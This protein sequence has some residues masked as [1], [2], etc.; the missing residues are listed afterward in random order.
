MKSRFACSLLLVFLFAVF[1]S[2]KTAPI[3]PDPMLD[4]TRLIPLESG[5]MVY[6][7]ADAQAARPILD[8]LPLAELKDKQSK[9]M[10]DK[11][12]TTVAAFYPP[13]SGRRFQLVAWGN[14]PSTRAGMALNMNKRWKKSRGESG[15][16]WYSASDRLSLALNSKQAFLAARLDTQNNSPFAPLP[17]I[18]TPEGFA[19]FR[20]NAVLSCWLDDPGPRINQVMEAMGIPLQIPAERIFISLFQAETPPAAERQYEALIRMRLPSVSQ[21]RALLTLFSLAGAFLGPVQGGELQ[22][23]VAVMMAVLFSN[24]PALNDRDLN[25]KSAVLGEKEIA[26]LFELFSL[27]YSGHANL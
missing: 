2:C 11:T 18:E 10:I 4:D 8:L 6:L 3:I 16:Y 12:R 27:Y 5:A 7:F 23:P 13:E 22:D 20:R 14:Y 26:L 24:P 21:A 19:E 15:S 25:I 17:G 1:T 9:Q